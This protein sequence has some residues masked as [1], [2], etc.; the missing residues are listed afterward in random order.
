M[1]RTTSRRAALKAGLRPRIKVWLEIDGEY[2]LGHGL[3]EMLQAVDRAGSIK[4]AA[5]DLGKSYRYVWGRIKEA[6]E[7]LGGQ[8]VESHVGGTG[9][10]RSLLTAPARRLVADYLA[11]RKRMRETMNREFTRRFGK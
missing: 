8:L 6:E 7:T 5:S 11:L 10:Q 3:C 4:Q 9:V 1:P 2:A